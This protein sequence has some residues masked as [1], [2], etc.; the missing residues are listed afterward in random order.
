MFPELSFFILKMSKQRFFA[1]SPVEG[2]MDVAPF[3]IR[4]LGN[5]IPIF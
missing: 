3:L 2:E 4:T 5:G 1:T